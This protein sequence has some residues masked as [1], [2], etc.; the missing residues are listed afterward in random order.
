VATLRRPTYLVSTGPNAFD[1]E[2]TFKRTKEAFDSKKIT[3]AEYERQ[4]A[5]IK[6]W[7]SVYKP[8]QPRPQP[9]R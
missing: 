8:P 3:Q 2:T 5:L 6:Q 9:Q 1:L 7:M 4:S